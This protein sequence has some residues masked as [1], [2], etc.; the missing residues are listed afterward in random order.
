MIH[1]QCRDRFKGMS[2]AVYRH[3]NRARATEIA[4]VFVGCHI[5]LANYGFTGV[6]FFGEVVKKFI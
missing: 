5:C 6:V 4:N 2:G 1:Q 3:G